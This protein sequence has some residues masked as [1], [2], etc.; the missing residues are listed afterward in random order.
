MESQSL[1]GIKPYKEVLILTL[2]TF[3]KLLF[4]HHFIG[5]TQRYWIINVL[6]G[7]TIFGIYLWINLIKSEKRVKFLLVSYFLV[8]LLLFANTMYYSHFVTLMPIHIIYQIRHLKGV[9]NSVNNL[10][11]FRYLLFLIDVILLAILQRK[12]SWKATPIMGVARRKNY[13][14]I[15]LIAIF[16]FGSIQGVYYNAVGYYTPLNLGVFN[17][18]IYDL[19]T[20]L[21]RRPPDLEYEEA[22][23]EILEEEELPAIVEYHGLA[24]GRNVFV[25]QAESLQSF[26]LGRQVNGQWITPNL[27]QLMAEDTFYF[28]RYYEQVGWGNTSDAEFVTQSGYHASTKTYSYKQ[29]EGKNL[30]SLPKIL[31]DE[32]YDTAVFHGNE[33]SFWNRENFYPYF[34]INHFIGQEDLEEE[35]MIGMGIGDRSLF[36]QSIPFI[37]ELKQPF[38]SVL[39]TLTSHYP[40]PLDEAYKMIEVGEPYEETILGGYFETV[41]YLD[42]AIGD[43]IDQLK[44]AGIY[45]N[46]MFIIYGDHHGLKVHDEETSDIMGHFL[47]KEYR[48]DEMLRVPLIIHIPNGGVQKEI[49]TVGGMVD[50]FPTVSNLLGI[51]TGSLKLIGKDLLNSNDNFALS[52]IHTAKGSF[53][54]DDYIFVMSR[55]GIF[56]NSEAWNI[57]TGEAADIEAFR[58]GFERALTEIQLSEYVL[59][60]ELLLIKSED[61]DDYEDHINN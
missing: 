53:I 15:A 3:I 21:V 8:S 48:E 16:V 45:E 42:A 28:S 4:F 38:Y 2:L 17:Y 44:E 7:V 9:S 52:L 30:V 59:D 37:K 43:F 31:R 50:F 18:H 22:W 49:T 14:V 12:V 34:G 60:N 1:N 26:V 54:K 33:K 24:E 55:D 6:N 23:T 13:K 40:Y 51:D 35:E 11:Q 47:G 57:K 5:I 39:I 10:M 61:E 58:E 20:F 36:R 41:N 56:E 29:Y 19:A 32:G 46:S 25:I 27:N